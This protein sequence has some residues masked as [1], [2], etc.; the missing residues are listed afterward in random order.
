MVS[1]F[2][3]DNLGDIFDIVDGSYLSDYNEFE[4]GVAFRS[5]ATVSTT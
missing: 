1:Q 4:I 3:E 2:W 5:A